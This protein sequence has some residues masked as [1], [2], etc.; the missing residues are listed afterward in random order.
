MLG[1]GP[2]VQGLDFEPGSDQSKGRA[3]G[4]K[5]KAEWLIP[6]DMGMPSSLVAGLLVPEL[7]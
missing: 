3:G 5:Q 6:I 4:R 1:L 7:S 2:E